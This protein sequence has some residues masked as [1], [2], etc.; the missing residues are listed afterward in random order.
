MTCLAIAGCAHAQT[1]TA[2]R[3]PVREMPTTVASVT[4]PA[5]ETAPVAT[6]AEQTPAPPLA[7][8][9]MAPPS[10]HT[11]PFA[12]PGYQLTLNEDWVGR[13]RSDGL[14]AVNAANKV[15]LLLATTPFSGSAHAFAT[16]QRVMMMKEDIT[17]EPM[18]NITV[19]G[20]KG[21]TF[22]SHNDTTQ[23][24]LSTFV[25]GQGKAFIFGCGSAVDN[26]QAAKV[27]SDALKELHITSAN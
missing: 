21:I 11:G 17:C 24:W 13:S 25:D 3:A 5:P 20:V 4:T 16:Q 7:D 15:K 12:G 6:V 18:K 9:P 22:A 8:P 26:K 14:V 2:D 23:A 10:I 19:N 27:C 1:K